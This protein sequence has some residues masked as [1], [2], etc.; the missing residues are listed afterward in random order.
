MNRYLANY[1]IVVK[2]RCDN[3]QLDM[4]GIGVPNSEMKHQQ[5]KTI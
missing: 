2:Y 3:W 4:V 1:R 5:N